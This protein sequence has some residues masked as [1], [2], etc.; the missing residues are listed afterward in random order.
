MSM[1]I[2]SANN[3]K[4]LLLLALFDQYILLHYQFL[5]IQTYIA[6]SPKVLK[7][8]VRILNIQASKEDFA[9]LAIA[10]LKIK[11]CYVSRER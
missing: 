10:F 7:I 5:N 2:S 3:L 6:N 1:A 11:T 4:K 9:L 8:K